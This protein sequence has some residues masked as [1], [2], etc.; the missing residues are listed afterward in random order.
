MSNFWNFIFRNN[1][2]DESR[3]L[4]SRSDSMA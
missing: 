3:T 1:A 4:L 2:V